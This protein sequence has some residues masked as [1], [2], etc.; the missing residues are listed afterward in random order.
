[1]CW[2]WYVSAESK[3]G[4][5]AAREAGPLCLCPADEAEAEQEKAGQADRSVRGTDEEG[6]EGIGPGNKTAQ[7][8]KKMNE[9]CCC[10]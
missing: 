3:G 6:E 1:M 10:Y 4:H 2:L 8:E 9:L 5:Q 7:E